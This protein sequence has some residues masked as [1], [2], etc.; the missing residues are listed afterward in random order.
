M[1]LVTSSSS[2]AVLGIPMRLCQHLEDAN[3]KTI[4]QLVDYHGSWKDIPHMGRS[5]IN[6]LKKIVR[7]LNQGTDMILVGD[8]IRTAPPPP[9]G[10][11]S[12]LALSPSSKAMHCLRSC[13]IENISDLTSATPE[14]MEL[15][16]KKAPRVTMSMFRRLTW[17][18]NEAI[19]DVNVT[20]L[21]EAQ[22]A[23]LT[24]ATRYPAMPSVLLYACERP[25]ADQEITCTFTPLPSSAYPR[26]NPDG[27]QVTVPP[28]EK[29]TT[30]I[31]TYNVVALAI[32]LHILRVLEL[33][34]NGIAMGDLRDTMP[35]GM[36]DEVFRS[37]LDELVEQRWVHIWR[38]ILVE[39]R[40][41][42]LE[43]YVNSIEDQRRR[44]ILQ[45]RL[46]GLTMEQLAAKHGMTQQRV[47]DILRKMV[48]RFPH[49]LE[50]RYLYIVNHYEISREDFTDAFQE[51]SSVFQF[52]EMVRDRSETRRPLEQIL[53]DEAIPLPLRSLAKTI[54]LRHYILIDG[55][56]VERRRTALS[57]YLV[58]RYCRKPISIDN[59]FVLY[60]D[61]MVELGLEDDVSL[62]LDPLTYLNRLSTCNYTLWNKN[63]RFRYYPLA[64]MD[65]TR[66]LDELALETMGDL[67][68]SA[69]KLVRDHPDLMADYDIHDEFELHNLLK[70]I[71][72][73]ERGNVRFTRM[74]TILVG[75]PDR[76]RQVMDLMR[77]HAPILRLDLAR[78]YEEV[79]GA[80]AATVNSNY[81]RCLDPYLDRDIYRMD[82]PDLPPE[83]HHRMKE[84]LTADFYRMEDVERIFRQEFP[85][86][87]RER[88]NSFALHHLGY[89]T[90]SNYVISSRYSGAVE[91]F[92]KIFSEN[93]FV[94]LAGEY[95]DLAGISA[96]NCELLVQKSHRRVVECSPR[97]YVTARYLER[98]EI[99]PK[100]M[101][102]YCIAVRNYVPIGTYFTVDSLRAA[103]FDHPLH[104][105]GNF[106]NWFFASILAEDKEHISSRRLGRNRVFTPGARNFSMQGFYRYVLLQN[107]G[108]MELRSFTDTIRRDYGCN[109]KEQA[110]LGIIQ[111]SDLYY[112]S[113]LGEIWPSYPIY[114]GVEAGLLNM[115]DLENLNE[116]TI[117]RL[118]DSLAGGA[119]TNPFFSRVVRTGQRGKGR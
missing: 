112:D 56:L 83:M 48:V 31:W 7:D 11:F 12:I 27:S 88:I 69:L 14:T 58:K 84:V 34:P 85:G 67:E 57:E 24:E 51:D 46:Q 77:E 102:D 13:G 71:W 64:D 110:V 44:I 68:F 106:G 39:I 40:Y 75:N 38:D 20:T 63:R 74:P 30:P 65:F 21:T 42:T 108:V 8:G 47:S 29:P 33:N 26:Q 36:P 115:E 60:E 4:G 119:D 89:Q 15:L 99:T 91:Y 86:E 52:L 41:P 80:K 81:F 3:I 103:G 32:R 10:M 16:H 5:G 79:Y 87:S 116:E 96:F 107:G 61:K 100:D 19:P 53:N 95:H 72:P 59:F 62:R 66:L 28:T 78:L 2:I 82:L 104:H 49:L 118:E 18:W 25:Y 114:Y 22:R 94:N 45:E 6:M 9:R 92:R 55:I 54:V 73:P 50:S 113:L 97:V 109:T 101:E 17:L 105:R 98:L 93:N 111:A 1:L 76:D 90:C 117:A 35:P 37:Y 43:E 23:W 70:K